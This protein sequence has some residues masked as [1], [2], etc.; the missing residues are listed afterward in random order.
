VLSS[1]GTVLRN[2]VS[3]SVQMNTT[4]LTGTPECKF[5]LSDGVE[6]DDCTFHGCVPLGKFDAD[7]T[8]T[9]IPPDGEKLELLRYRLTNINLP[10]QMIP[11]IWVEPNSTKVYLKIIAT[12]SEL[13]VADNMVITIPVPKTT[14][15]AKI[16]KTF[17]RAKYEPEQQEIVWRIKH[18]VGQSECVINVE[19]DSVVSATL[20]RNQPPIQVEF[21]LPMFSAS[22]V[23]VRFARFDDKAGRVNRWI[24]YTTRAGQCQIQMQ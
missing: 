10:F 23:H 20:A 17:G 22:G 18:F 9:F 16:K 11:T 1:T 6:T 24:R 7:R 3:G 8:I 21:E 13:L 12:F 15:K 19:V 5:G 14:T 2:E 4:K